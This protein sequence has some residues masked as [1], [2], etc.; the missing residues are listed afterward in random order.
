[1]HVMYQMA[2]ITG[3]NLTTAGNAAVL[4]ATAPLWTLV[5]DARMHGE[6]ISGRMWALDPDVVG[7]GHHDYRRERE[8]SDTRL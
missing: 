4:L 5:I 6:K 3:L 2:F 7:R 8:G 1:A